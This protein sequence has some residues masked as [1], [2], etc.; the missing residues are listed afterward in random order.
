MA[1][2]RTM[3]KQCAMV[4][5]ATNYHTE[6]GTELLR[7]MCEESWEVDEDIVPEM[8]KV[9]LPISPQ[10]Y[11]TDVKT[12]K[13]YVT[14][15]NGK[16]ENPFF[17]E[18]MMIPHDVA[19]DIEIKPL[20]VIPNRAVVI[21]TTGIIAS[22]IFEYV[23]RVAVRF[24]PLASEVLTW[25]E[26]LVALYLYSTAANFVS[27][28]RQLP[29]EEQGDFGPQ[30]RLMMPVLREMA[31]HCA[32][33]LAGKIDGQAAFPPAVFHGIANKYAAPEHHFATGQRL[34]SIEAVF[35][36]IDLLTESLHS[37]SPLL[38]SSYKTQHE[39][40]LKQLRL[41]AEDVLRVG[42]FRLAS[43]VFNFEKYVD[44]ISH[45][46][47]EA[48]RGELQPSKYV[49]T[50][51]E[52][53][54]RFIKYCKIEFPSQYIKE[55]FWIHFVQVLQRTLMRAFA[56]VKR[57]T[58]VIVTQMKVDAPA[59]LYNV[60]DAI[61]FDTPVQSMPSAEYMTTI[62][63]S[64][65]LDQEGREQWIRD[66]HNIY[67]RV[68]IVGFLAMTTHR[69]KQID[70]VLDYLKHVDMIPPAPKPF[71]PSSSRASTPPP[72][73]EVVPVSPSEAPPQKPHANGVQVGHQ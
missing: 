56:K 2:A 25:G 41:T 35:P 69:Q 21:G 72:S 54:K 31:L 71:N 53:L 14:K 12:V 43:A 65:F 27:S 58:D 18:H 42:M 61:P 68:E 13:N 60:R 10:A 44:E 24:P 70:D 63:D 47:F 64:F 6:R 32:P 22:R 17:T 66:H 62:L 52:D 8:F 20:D 23:C 9:V 48:R 16:L 15:N 5:V 1:S 51:V 4:C 19:M 57:L 7:K 50:M 37:V 38:I 34:T 11:R 73:P 39:E 67:T 40:F 33:H 55:Q 30:T 3:V 26:E 49:Y 36:L 28:R 46:K 45:F 29:F 59:V